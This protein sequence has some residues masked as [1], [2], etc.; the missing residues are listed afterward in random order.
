MAYTKLVSLNNGHF[1][2]S[3]C[4]FNQSNMYSVDKN[5]KL[6]KEGSGRVAICKHL[7]LIHWSVDRIFLYPLLKIEYFPSLVTPWSA[8]ITQVDL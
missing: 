3:A 4:N 2:L 8:T 7:G 5:D 1:D 6:S